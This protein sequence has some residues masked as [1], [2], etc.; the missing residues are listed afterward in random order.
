MVGENGSNGKVGDNWADGNKS[1]VK[2]G[3]ELRVG[4]KYQAFSA[5]LT[6]ILTGVDSYLL[7]IAAGIII[8]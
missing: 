4:D 5:M 1:V 7:L 6:L 8:F 3:V 2:W